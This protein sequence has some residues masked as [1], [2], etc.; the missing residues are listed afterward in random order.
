MREV[1]LVTGGRSFEGWKAM[2]I[3]RSMDAMCGGFELE[4]SEIWPGSSVSRHI[5]PGEACAVQL[6]GER[7][8]TGYVDEVEVDEDAQR[9]TVRVSGRDKT[10]DLVDCSA[11]HKGGQWRGRT[12]AQIAADLC[13]PFGIQVTVAAD[14][15]KALPSFA[16]QEGETVFCALERLARI[17]ALLLVADGQGNLVMTRAGT[18][19][20]TTALVRG[21]NVL[22]A[23]GLLSMRDRF[24]TYIAKGQAAGTDFFN[25]TAASQ[26]TAT[27]SDALVPR[28]RPMVLLGESQDVAASLKQRVQWEANVRA[29]RSTDIE[30]TVQGWEHAEGLWQPNTLARLI[31]PALRIDADLLIT[32]VTFELSESG[33]LTQLAMTRADAYTVLPIKAVSAAQAAQAAN[34]AFWSLPKA[35]GAK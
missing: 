30:V 35:E 11:I 23:R 17:R 31:H 15:G 34:G 18:R 5:Q 26:V 32:S 12:I 16:L 2:R 22:A 29:A 1:E 28:Y 6:G 4:V 25:G 9:H 7:V 19:R 10:A 21:Q 27:A 13:A 3:A 33:S 20:V 8:I 24:S 14:V